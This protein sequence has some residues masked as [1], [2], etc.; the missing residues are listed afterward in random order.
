MFVHQVTE[1][2]NR[3]RL[4]PKV[5]DYD[6][7]LDFMNDIEGII[8]FCDSTSELT[9][10]QLVSICNVFSKRWNLVLDTPNDYT[11]NQKIGTNPLWIKFASDIVAGTNQ[12]ALQILIPSA[13]NTRDSVLPWTVFKSEDLAGMF[14]SEDGKA[15]H[16]LKGLVW[17]IKNQQPIATFVNYKTVKLCPL[18]LKELFRI[19]VKPSTTFWDELLNSVIPGKKGSTGWTRVGELP[20]QVLPDLLDLIDI[21]FQEKN[22]IV[23]SGEFCNQLLIWSKLLLDY[24]VDDVNNLYGQEI[25]VGSN[26]YYLVEILISCLKGD[27]EDLDQKMRGIARW[28][29]EAD[30]SLISDKSELASVY[31]ELK[32]GR[33]FG[34][35]ELKAALLE[36]DDVSDTQLRSSIEAL[37]IS[38][39]EKSTI[40]G[41]IIK[42][43][44]AIY[45]DR[46]FKIKDTDADY[47]RLQSGA[48][49]PWI[50]LARNLQGAKLLSKN[51]YCILMPSVTRE[52]DSVTHMPVSYFPLSHY[53]LS[54]SGRE[55]ILLDNCLA[56]FKRNGTFWNCNNYNSDNPIQRS[57]PLTDSELFRMK[58]AHSKFHK[59]IERARVVYDDPCLKR[60]TILAVKALVD[61]SLH[62]SGLTSLVEYSE[63]EIHGA[64]LAYQVFYEFLN[65]LDEDELKRLLSQRILLY[66]KWHNVQNI[67][68]EVR[69]GA[70]QVKLEEQGGKH[71]PDEQE[72]CIALAGKLFAKLVMDYAPQLMFRRDLEEHEYIG[73]SIRRMREGSKRKIL[74]EEHDRAMFKVQTILVS[75]FT[76]DFSGSTLPSVPINLSCF[77]KSVPEVVKNIFLKLKPLIESNDYSKVA[78]VLHDIE[79]SL[80]NPAVQDY[81]RF[82]W[83]WWM[84][85]PDPTLKQWLC[86][87]VPQ[88]ASQSL[89]ER[90]NIYTPM[91]IID[92][93]FG[94]EDINAEDMR[95]IDL[96]IDESLS[97][98]LDTADF[99][100]NNVL[101]NVRL[102]T[103]LA[104]VSE[105]TKHLILTAIDISTREQSSLEAFREKWVSSLKLR[106]DRLLGSGATIGVREA[107]R[108][109]VSL[110][111]AS[112]RGI[113]AAVVRRRP[114]SDLSLSSSAAVARLVDS[115]L[116]SSAL[117]K[118]VQFD[119]NLSAYGSAAFFTQ[120]A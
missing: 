38:L 44:E 83:S 5:S 55:L 64:S 16:T 61:G 96:F 56:H 78:N 1:F 120:R 79:S 70:A 102:S 98:C 77:T 58:F 116:K 49:D 29:Y 93:L 26:Q 99:L 85:K 88:R 6:Y 42:Q 14:V 117:L 47:L 50:R 66:S 109:R 89:Y 100:M 80:I 28:I 114:S 81:N 76:H 108:D 24:V 110:V 69:R 60:E 37:R 113:F 106:V 45:K 54:E 21:Y 41:P 68:D 92:A 27:A 95:F 57:D 91:S 63:Q 31:S 30:Q 22:E 72:G 17:R 33:W 7:D 104:H 97:Q 35:D 2:I 4:C 40:D 18:S 48:N 67:L 86:S 65:K 39:D 119:P 90:C 19:A 103:M 112:S 94:L 105:T 43:V 59:Y 10:T 8:S 53:I 118:S 34:V 52:I 32:A 74:R 107:P 51:Y 101:I 15:L 75:L 12:E 20:M 84:F 82:V 111:D 46:W 36:L 73:D 9:S 11:R 23:R 13:K 25:K 87:L 115:L 71:T 3:I 62:A